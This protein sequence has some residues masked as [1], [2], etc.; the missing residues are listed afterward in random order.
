MCG[1]DEKSK[2]E[3]AFN[4]ITNKFNNEY[5]E[6]VDALYQYMYSYINDYMFDVGLFTDEI[7][8]LIGIRNHSEI[9]NYILKL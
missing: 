3:L 1:V 5:D 9:L 7:E 4:T 2:E 8:N 6:V